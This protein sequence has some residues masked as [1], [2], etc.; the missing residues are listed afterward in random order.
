M[1]VD[2]RMEFFMVLVLLGCLFLCGLIFLP[3]V[4][5]MMLFFC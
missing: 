4:A 3:F 1:Q 2:R 5:A